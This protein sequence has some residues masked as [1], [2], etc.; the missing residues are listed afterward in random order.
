[1]FS[2]NKPR[3]VYL[4]SKTWIDRIAGAVM[5]ALGARLISEAFISRS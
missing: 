1:V 3:A 5:S 4:H 2:A